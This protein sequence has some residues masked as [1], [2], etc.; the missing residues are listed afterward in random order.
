MGD[1]MSPKQIWPDDT[2][3]TVAKATVGTFEWF[4]SHTGEV[5]PI[6]KPI[7][8]GKVAVKTE[9]FTWIGP[10]LK[11]FAYRKRIESDEPQE[12]KAQVPGMDYLMG[13]FET[14]M[15]DGGLVPW[16]MYSVA[17]STVVNAKENGKFYFEDTRYDTLVDTGYAF[18][19]ALRTHA[20]ILKVH[21]TWQ[22]LDSPNIYQAAAAMP[23]SATTQICAILTFVLQCTLITMCFLG[24][25]W[26]TFKVS[27]HP[28]E[29]KWEAFYVSM[30]P[31][32]AVVAFNI[33]PFV[34]Y[35]LN[36]AHMRDDVNFWEAARKKTEGS[37]SRILVASWYVADELINRYLLPFLIVIT[38]LLIACTEEMM[39]AVLN[40]VALLFISVL[41]DEV[42]AYLPVDARGNVIAM[43][44]EYIVGMHEDQARTHNCDDECLLGD[45]AVLPD[46][47]QDITIGC[48][49]GTEPVY[50][51]RKPAELRIIGLHHEANEG[52]STVPNV[53]IDP[54]TSRGNYC[55]SKI[56]YQIGDRHGKVIEWLEFTPY[57]STQPGGGA[58]FS[59]GQPFDEDEYPIQEFV[60]VLVVVNKQFYAN[61]YSMRVLRFGTLFDVDKFFNFFWSEPFFTKPATDIETI[62]KA[63][64]RP[65]STVASTSEKEL[66]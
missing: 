10:Y 39:D 58:P 37:A 34:L 62:K 2:G 17:M 18:L 36:T 25:D 51:P 48:H 21:R 27:I 47:Y 24:L 54:T 9:M 19:H 3:T 61:M 44:V 15:L 28:P 66:L 50:L 11:K 65:S 52:N 20:H 30:A 5:I 23:S 43:S 53:V 55:F 6:G 31:V 38:F 60:G 42:V 49:H 32:A 56:R 12:E 33:V 57:D 1:S 22:E 64:K 59:T 14:C 40:S 8:P 46:T 45:K 35:Q 29:L 16:E 26:E 41:D 13:L 4:L 7:P 63:P